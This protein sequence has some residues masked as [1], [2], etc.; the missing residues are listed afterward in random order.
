MNTMQM[1]PIL[2]CWIRVAALKGWASPMA[3]ASIALAWCAPSHA[4]FS[5]DRCKTPNNTIMLVRLASGFRLVFA[6]T[7]DG[8]D[9][10]GRVQ[11][12]QSSGVTAGQ[13]NVSGGF[14]GHAAQGRGVLLNIHW[15]GRSSKGISQTYFKGTL[16]NG[17][18]NG[19]ALDLQNGHPVD[20]SASVL[21][22][23]PMWPEQSSLA[24]ATP[25]LQPGQNQ[26]RPGSD[27]RNF[28]LAAAQPEQCR[29]A[30]VADAKC[31]SF[32]YAKP[33]VQG[34]K[35][36][37]WLKDAVPTA[38][39][40]DCC[41]SGVVRAQPDGPARVLKNANVLKD[42]VRSSATARP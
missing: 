19:T 29:A 15:E 32:T 7:R 33:G 4:Q 3:A 20:A 9:I 24:A 22:G 13:G 12:W 25:P 5:T 2:T 30:C 17:R 31:R 41:V 37:C 10:R 16:H 39:T 11:G 27:Y 34:P 38:R 35:A 36:R 42:A 18:G 28:D 40:S 23:C 8:D 1:P 26:D 6:L 14:G 21:N